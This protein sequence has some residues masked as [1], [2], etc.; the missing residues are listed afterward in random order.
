MVKKLLCF[1]LGFLCFKCSW[2]QNPTSDKAMTA[3]YKAAPTSRPLNG[4]NTLKYYLVKFKE[5]D[6]VDIK[7]LRPVKR[8]SY[9]FYVVATAA[10]IS[11]DA[12]IQE[13][14]PANAL[15]KAT[16]NLVQLLQKHP[17]GKQSVD[18]S[19]TSHSDSVISDIKKYG[20]ITAQTE[21]TVTLNISLQRL[22]DLL[23]QPYVTFA[24]V[25]RKAHAELVI[26]DID[27][28]INQISAIA[29][30]FPGI[31]G[32]GINVAIKE[33]RYDNDLD[34]LS[35]TFTSFPAAAITSG[36]A[37]IMATLIGG[38]GNSFIRGLGAAP[39]VRFTSSDFA[40]LL[41]D[42]TAIF[43]AF[44]IGVENHS[45]GIGIENYYGVEAVAYDQQV[46]ANDSIIHVFSSG[47]IG[48][49]APTTGLYNGIANVANLSGTFKQ[50]K[51]VLVIGGT[52]QTGVPAGLSSAG[53][54][55]DG[56]VKPE[57]VSN[58]EDGTSGAAALVSGTVALLQQ[59]YKK[60]FS[61]LPSAAL[62]KS[63]LINSA[64]DIGLPNVDHKT[65][66]GQLNALEALRALTDNRFKKGTVSNQQQVDY[67]INVPAGSSLFKVS[68]AWND[69]PAALNAPKAL[70]NDLDLSVTTPDGQN[71][72]PWS[73][74]AYPSTDSLTKP[75][76][77]RRDTLNN[78]EQVTLQNPVA[79][80]YIIHVKGSKIASGTQ[81]FY[82]AHGATVANRFE[83]TYPSGQNQ[84]FAA[85]ENYLR[86]QSSF[87]ATSGQLSVSYDHG[88]T[89]K[90]ISSVTLKDRYYDWTAPDVFTTAMLKM[91]IGSQSFISKGFV[92]SQPLSLQVGYNC[93][94]GTL[95]H[96]KAQP[97]SKGYV[98]YTVKDNLLQKL[99]TVT[100][101]TIIIPAALQTSS[102]F[103][104][105]AQGDGFEGLKS[106]TIDVNNQGVG[107]YVKTLLANV[108]N[109]TIVLN[110]QIG[111]VVNLKSI[112]WQ[113]QTGSNAYANLGT[114]T[115]GS[116][117]AYQFTD[118][119]PK[120]GIQYYRVELQ[121]NDGKITYSNLASAT[122]LQASQFTLYP[123][124][125]STQLNILSG[126]IN[127]Y[128]FKLYDAVGHVRLE[129]TITQ[130]QNTFQLN[131]SPGVYIYVIMFKG[132]IL[133]RGKLIKV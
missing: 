41:P 16:D 3:L 18:L 100:D 80:N 13:V 44:D 91:D 12:N 118:A 52:D 126:D 6:K 33:E 22:T 5:P 56:R 101:T 25:T 62:I 102:Y 36:H 105:S 119:N 130:L 7:K 89:W 69:L 99:S 84:L 128:D 87:S 45:Y 66:Y 55:Y 8:V 107:C 82:I 117:L 112:T 127:T 14:T 73:L 61:Q 46:M 38:N 34:L 95:L 42:S 40:R 26:N 125:V 111:S 97:G 98:V 30:N 131:L 132:K 21:N 63:I 108:V 75:A 96:W 23:Q 48:T 37:T 50:A 85:G 4:N 71:L 77:R 86:W 9:N 31:D 104:V 35:R 57:L 121:T 67:A 39:K 19:I 32:S 124:P 133:T 65:G 2:A 122:F 1:I 83:W 47:N 88:A 93:T 17:S 54:A 70:I 109:N 74:S 24:N 114:T 60:Q 78:T 27:L 123:N 15:W 59:A 72:L 115:V 20:E 110:L 116:A 29:D 49:T 129:Q 92:L 103:A 90:A 113:K 76:V 28:G 11:T 79:G 58:G 68:L 106:L 51:N 64:D 94:D 10:N 120:N 43:K 53:P 81:T